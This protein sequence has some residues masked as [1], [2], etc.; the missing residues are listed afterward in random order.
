MDSR[1]LET[2]FAAIGRV[3]HTFLVLRLLTNTTRQVQKAQV[4]RDPHTHESRGF[5]FVT[6]ESPAE[7]D[8]AIAALNG[9]EFFGKTLAI[10][11]VRS[12]PLPL[13]VRR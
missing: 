5:G 12:L 3:T 11:K 1:D 6:M 4:M 13:R 8:A 7:A 9:Q 2:H 10:E